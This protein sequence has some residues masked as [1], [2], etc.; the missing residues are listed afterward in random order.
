M[1]S[2]KKGTRETDYRDPRNSAI[3]V[4]SGFPRAFT[5]MDLLHATIAE[6]GRALARGETSSE[7]LTRAYLARIERYGERLNAY[8]RVFTDEAVQAARASDRERASGKE[9]GPLH[10][11][12]F[13]LKDIIDIRGYPTT[14][15]GVLLPDEPA[16]AD[17]EVTRRLRAAGAVLLGKLNLHEYAWGGTNANVHY[18]NAYNPWKQGYSPGGSSGGSA[19]AVVAGL[20]AGALGTDTLGS[21]RIPSSYC[22]CVGLKTTYGLVSKR[23]VYPL[24]WTLDT[25]GPIVRCVEDAAIVLGAIAGPDPD[26]PSSALREAPAV[27]LGRE[28]DLKGVRLGLVRDY[29]LAHDG[30]PEE[31]EVRPVVEQ[32]IA[33]LESLGAERVEIDLSELAES[34][35]VVFTIG[36]AEASAIHEQHLDQHPDQIGEDVRKRLELGRK[37]SGVDIARAHHRAAEIRH[38]A[39][40][41]MK[42]LD[43]LVFPSTA[44]A[45]HAFDPKLALKTANYTGPVNL[46]G[47]PAISVPCGFNREG[48]PVGLQLAGVPFS[49]PALLRIAH[50]YEQ[51]TDWVKQKPTDF[52]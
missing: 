11:I 26:E 3:P 48:L 6:L 20:A 27:E 18:G 5:D 45:S 21:V 8:L 9:I 23:G 35:A 22:G 38:R 43:A 29:S 42:G 17:A 52:S 31:I 49:E 7:E 14:A 32:A 13:A 1:F 28:P 47:W 12:P 4:G 39:L 15:G 33:R 40:R 37:L 16:V 46:L 50:A 19:A 51:A 41:A 36:F 2:R 44:T 30:T 10:G 34:R 25:V 24:A